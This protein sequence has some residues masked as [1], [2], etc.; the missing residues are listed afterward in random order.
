MPRKQNA[1]LENSVEK[2]DNKC[3]EPKKNKPRITYGEIDADFEALE[4]EINKTK[5]DLLDILGKMRNLRKKYRTCVKYN[6]EE[7]KRTSS[8]SSETN[9]KTH[10][11]K[12]LAEFLG[13]SEDIEISCGEVLYAFNTYIK[14]NKLQDT[15]NVLNIK[16]DSLLKKLLKIGKGEKLTMHNL[17]S[18]LHKNHFI[19]NETNT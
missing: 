15:K 4:L 9:K 6:I 18:Y 2:L 16:P 3:D 19:E 10:I 14:N 11:S 7:R 5:T 13:K 17:P 8:D 12:E 1:I